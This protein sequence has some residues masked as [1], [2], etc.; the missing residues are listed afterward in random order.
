VRYKAEEAKVKFYDKTR[1]LFQQ[2]AKMTSV[3]ISEAN[4]IKAGI[5]VSEYESVQVALKIYDEAVKMAGHARRDVDARKCG[6]N[7]CRFSFTN[8]H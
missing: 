8:Y 3:Q 6:P 7:F 1:R 2:K 4:A 5:N